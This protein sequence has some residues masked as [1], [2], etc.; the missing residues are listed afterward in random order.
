[1]VS[2]S[3]ECSLLDYKVLSLNLFYPIY[4][5]WCEIYGSKATYKLP[6]FNELLTKELSKLYPD[7]QKKK[8]KLSYV[9]RRFPTD[10]CE[11]FVNTKNARIHS[12]YEGMMNLNYHQIILLEDELLIDRSEPQVKDVN[13]IENETQF[14]EY[15]Q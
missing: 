3:Q 13:V 11:K 9:T 1:M 12:I 7:A 8:A 6:K 14:V 5:S 4:L 15:K 2:S 10:A